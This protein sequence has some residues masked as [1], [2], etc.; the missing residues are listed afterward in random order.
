MVI[1][2]DAPRIDF[3]VELTSELKRVQQEG[4]YERD[5][6]YRVL[7][8]KDRLMEGSVPPTN[9]EF[10]TSQPT[11]AE[12][13]ET[14]N[15]FW[16]D[17]TYVAKCLVRDEFYFAKH[18]LDVSLHHDLLGK[19]ISWHIG[20]DSNWKSNPGVNGR[21]FKRQIDPGVWADI[22]TTFAGADPQDNWRA[23]YQTAKVFSRLATEIAS[24][25]G[26]PYPE[27]LECDVTRY[28]KDIQELGESG[29]LNAAPAV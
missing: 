19:V 10:D 21:W 4:G 14:V 5:I 23:M 29:A 12:F 17:I 26:Y 6:G 2:A 18:M 3:G 15:T 22:E 25:L 11:Q 20:M 8:D 28:L 13:S 16:W 9:S 1:F 27:K 7:L 24:R